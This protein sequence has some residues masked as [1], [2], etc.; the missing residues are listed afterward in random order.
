MEA[1]NYINRSINS[2]SQLALKI[3]KQSANWFSLTNKFANTI[4]IYKDKK[5]REFNS[6]TLINVL[7]KNTNSFNLHS[8]FKINTNKSNKNNVNL[9]KTMKL[10]ESKI[11]KKKKIILGKSLIDKYD[12]REKFINWDIDKK[13]DCKLLNNEL[14]HNAFENFKIII[15]KKSKKIIEKEKNRRQKD[16]MRRRRENEE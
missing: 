11:I 7:K 15:K 13:N 12:I 4:K 2:Y 1:R 14:Y 8:K 6:R 16:R 10:N 3:T 9:N 5:D